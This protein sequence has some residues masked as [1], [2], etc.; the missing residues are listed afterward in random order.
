VVPSRFDARFFLARL[1]EGV[2]A[3]A[4][5][6]ESD[7]ALWVSPG[8]A[9]ERARRGEM[10]MMFPTY[11]TLLALAAA[12]TAEEALGWA[13]SQPAQP[14]LPRVVWRRGRIGIALPWEEEYTRA[15]SA[16]WPGWWAEVHVPAG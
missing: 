5:M 10:P 8:E 13:R 3:S 15:P 14:V 11:M 16:P 9:L 2:T 4:D 6:I 1:P 7:R 12:K